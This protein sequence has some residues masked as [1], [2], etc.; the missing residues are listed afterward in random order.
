[1]SESPN[2]ENLLQM[3]IT[4]A[5]E[6]NKEGARAMLLK[7]LEADRKNDRAWFWLAYM[8]E[9]SDQRRQYL[10]NAVRAN[11][12]NQPAQQAL[13]KMAWQRS[14][15]EQRMLQMGIVVILAISVVA[16][17]LCLIALAAS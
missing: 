4:A 9:T 15:Q 13:K 12:R 6:G 14:S 7:V 17:L 3:G 1:M 10:E 16:M 2:L 8:A 11:P 5:K